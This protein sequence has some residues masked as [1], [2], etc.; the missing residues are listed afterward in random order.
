MILEIYNFV[1][2]DANPENWIVVAGKFLKFT[3]S[4]EIPR[5]AATHTQTCRTA[6]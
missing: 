4:I 6:F 1:F 3:K 2:Q 5:K